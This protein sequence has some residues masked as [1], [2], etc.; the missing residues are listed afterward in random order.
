MGIGTVNP[1]AKLEVA[2]PAGT[3]VR[4]TGPGGFGTT[5]AFDLATYDAGAGNAPSGSESS[6]PESPTVQV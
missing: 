5:V 4:V 1:G 2:G 3:S 6:C